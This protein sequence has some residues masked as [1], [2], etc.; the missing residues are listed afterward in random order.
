MKTIKIKKV[1]NNIDDVTQE[2][3]QDES[4]C[5]CVCV[6]FLNIITQQYGR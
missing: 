4:V 2:D 5:L 3:Q 6:S 1:D